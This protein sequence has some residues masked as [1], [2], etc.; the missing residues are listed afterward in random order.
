MYDQECS[1]MSVTAIQS[2]VRFLWSQRSPRISISVDRWGCSDARES[3]EKRERRKEKRSFEM[4]N[5]RDQLIG[6]LTMAIL[7]NKT[8]NE[9]VEKN[10]IRVEY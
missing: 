8:S 1:I 2:L 3:D 6:V 7:A 4:K 9:T 5:R 10:E